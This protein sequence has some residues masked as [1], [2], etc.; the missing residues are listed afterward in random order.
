V[1]NECNKTRP[2]EDP[3]EIW[4]GS[5]F[6]HHVLKKYQNPENEAK[7]PYA[8]WFLASKSPYTYGSWEYGD[9]YVTDITR[10]FKRIK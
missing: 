2:V 5:G 8:R 9:A 1:K 10:N 6:T 7:N 3:Y 4:E